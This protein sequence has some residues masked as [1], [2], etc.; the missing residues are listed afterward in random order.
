[1]IEASLQLNKFTAAGQRNPDFEGVRADFSV[2][3]E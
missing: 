2:S 3:G 1:M